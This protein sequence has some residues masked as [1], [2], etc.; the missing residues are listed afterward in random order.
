[1][2][3]A[4]PES[5]AQTL[6]SDAAWREEAGLDGP[7]LEAGQN[8]LDDEYD[9]DDDTDDDDDDDDDDMEEE[10]PPSGE[11]EE[12]DS[13]GTEVCPVDKRY[14]SADLPR[15]VAPNHEGFDDPAALETKE[16]EASRLIPV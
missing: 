11:E 7:C 3:V 16:E 2:G 9:D 15:T 6:T 1:M 5:E 12:E 4:N 14:R 13:F 10:K 8:D